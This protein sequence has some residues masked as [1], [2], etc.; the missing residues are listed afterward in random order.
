M[1][2]QIRA[3][4]WSNQSVYYGLYGVHSE[5]TPEHE[6][7]RIENKKKAKKITKQAHAHFSLS[8]FCSFSS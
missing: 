6:Q 2:L 7:T 4:E 5:W 8:T 1:A 3:D